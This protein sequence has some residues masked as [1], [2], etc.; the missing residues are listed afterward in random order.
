MY[1][2]TPTVYVCANANVIFVRVYKDIYIC[3]IYI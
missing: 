2:Y 3:M 1:M